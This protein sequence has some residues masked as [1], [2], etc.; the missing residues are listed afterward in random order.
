[1]I[2]P[3]FRSVSNALRSL[4][5]L[6]DHQ[7]AKSRAVLLGRLPPVVEAGIGV[8][9]LGPFRRRNERVAGCG[10][11]AVS[12]QHGNEPTYARIAA[13]QSPRLTKPGDSSPLTP[14]IQALRER[15]SYEELLWLGSSIFQWLGFRQLPG[16]PMGICI[17][18]RHTCQRRNKNEAGNL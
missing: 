5:A 14:Q 18:L 10:L 7:V 2:A 15:T 16:Q 8:R 9:E 3:R 17:L 13:V 11:R 1:M 12:L 4:S 6:Y